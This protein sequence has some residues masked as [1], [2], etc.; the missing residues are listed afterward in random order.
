RDPTGELRLS[1]ALEKILPG[2]LNAVRVRS[3]TGQLDQGVPANPGGG[4][5]AGE[6]E[7]LTD[8]EEQ[9]E[10]EVVVLI[11]AD[12]ERNGGDDARALNDLDLFGRHLLEL[13]QPL[14]PCFL[15]L[16]PAR[17]EVLLARHDLGLE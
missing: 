11:L 4:E 9:S 10:G 13:A 3:G 17:R 5:G 2:D 1:V 12:A 14:R 16:R 8:G 6:G 15:E 7:R